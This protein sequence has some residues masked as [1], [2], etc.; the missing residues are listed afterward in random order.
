[1][2]HDER[3]N[4]WPRRL[5]GAAAVAAA[6]YLGLVTGAV[7]L[8]LRIGRR[9]RALG[10]QHLDIAAP[11]EVVFDVIAQ[12]YLGRPT[13]AMSEKVRVLER[14]A[15]L[16]LAAHRTAIHGRLVATTVET[17]KFHRPDRVTF[18][19]VRGP[20]PH[21][22]EE[23]LLDD[24]D[25]RTGLTY[26]GEMAADLWQLGQWWADVVA[27]RW[28]TTVAGSLGAVKQEAERRARPG[29]H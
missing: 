9:A 20:V 8:D 5:I 22:T 3:M 4:A 10:P 28:E 27:R 26:R 29:Q 14:G 25:G 6:G 18:R 23:F 1:M 11:R 13:H 15:D 7:P 16:V 19:L 24:Q 2:R 12:P 17:V 21:V